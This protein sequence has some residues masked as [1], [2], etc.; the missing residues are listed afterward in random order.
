MANKH[1]YEV[2][3]RDYSEEVSR[4]K[5]HFG[6]VTAVSIAG[7]LTQI[8]ALR[9]SIANLISG[10]IAADKWVGDATV[11]SN[12]APASPNA[13]NELKL[14]FT[15]EG[16]TNHKRYRVELPCADPSKVIAGTDRVDLADTEVA[17]FVTAFEDIGRTPDDDEETVNVLEGRLV[18]RNI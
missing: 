3:V 12:A 15:Y 6:A 10:V 5:F 2:A 1:Y 13:Q 9:T 7:L 18:G 11:Q 4:T 17:A 8:G 14:Q 16:A